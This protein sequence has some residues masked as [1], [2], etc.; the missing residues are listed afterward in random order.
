VAKD[1]TAAWNMDAP[2]EAEAQPSGMV[3]L[4]RT[5]AEKKK[6][7]QA[8]LLCRP[9]TPAPTIPMASVL[10][11]GREPEEAGPEVFTG[12]RLQDVAFTP[13]WRSS[14]RRKRAGKNS[15]DREV[16]FQITALKLEG[17]G[18]GE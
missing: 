3:S 11:C 10:N 16:G 13:R 2:D 14:G 6:D 9:R 17:E 18:D 15:N 8:C 5:K 7:K 1:R 12:C 4:A